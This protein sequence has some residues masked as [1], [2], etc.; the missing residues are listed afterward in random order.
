MLAL[1]GVIAESIIELVG[2]C[3]VCILG[4]GLGLADRWV[5]IRVRV[6]VRVNN[7]VHN[8]IGPCVLGTW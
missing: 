8:S 2:V 3:Y 5:S 1:H 7:R 6:R 4:L